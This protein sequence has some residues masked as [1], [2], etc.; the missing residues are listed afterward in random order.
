M[1]R[2]RNCDFAESWRV[3]G[4]AAGMGGVVGGGI[5]SFVGK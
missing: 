1:T 2:K 5:I 3:G 4:G